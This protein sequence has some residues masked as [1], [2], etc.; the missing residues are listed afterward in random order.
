M[1]RTLKYLP[2]Y[3][4][5]A[6]S[7]LTLFFLSFS[8][9]LSTYTI[10]SVK[11][12]LNVYQSTT[13]TLSLLIVLGL[14][15]NYLRRE[16]PSSSI[17]LSAQSQ[18][19]DVKEKESVREITPAL[20]FQTLLESSHELI[21]ILNP[22]LKITYCSPYFTKLTGFT[23]K[24]LYSRRFF[25]LCS[26]DSRAALNQI[27]MQS[28]EEPEDSIAIEFTG[29]TK[30]NQEVGFKGTLLNKLSEPEI[31]GLVLNLQKKDVFSEER[32]RAIIDRVSD[33]F[34]SLN[35]EL[36][37][38]YA[39]K[40]IGEMTR[41]DPKTLIG[42]YIWDEFPE[43]VGSDTHRA[44]EKAIK[45]QVYVCN[46]DYFEPLNLWQEN[47][48]YPSR[49]GLSVFIR[50]IS[51][52]KIAELAL[53][54]SE[55]LFKALVENLEDIITIV[56]KEGNI[57]Y[58]SPAFER[59]TGFTAK[60]AIGTSGASFVHPNQVDNSKLLLSELFK[61]PGV[62]IKR[63]NQLL[64]KKGHY[65]WVEGSVINLLHDPNIKAI[66]SNYKDISDRMASESALRK[67]E[68]HY[69]NLFQNLIQAYAYCEIVYEGEKVVDFK[70]LAMNKA[71]EK[72][73]GGRDVIGKRLG[74]IYA[75]GNEHQ[76]IYFE[77]I[78]RLLKEGKPQ[79][80]EPY[81]AKTDKWYSVTFYSPVKDRVVIL[82]D[83]I[84]EKKKYNEQQSLFQSIVNSSQDAIF[85]RDQEGKITSWNLSA[86]KLFGY[87]TAE[88]LG[89][90]IKQLIPQ[91]LIHEWKDI[92]DR[93][94]AEIQINHFETHRLTKS[95]IEIP[96]SLTVSPILSPQGEF[97]GASIIARDI[98]E[99]QAAENKI[100][101]SETN[102]RTI[103]ENSTET[104]TLL[105]K[106]LTIKTFNSKAR[107]C[108]ILQFGNTVIQEN[109]YFLNYVHPERREQ[110]KQTLN[111]VLKGEQIQY[112]SDFY[113][114]KTKPY[115]FQA[116]F[117]PVTENNQV[118]GICVAVTDITKSKLAE[119]QI[120]E[121]EE[122][123]KAVFE[124]TTQGFLL[125]EPDGTIKLLNQNAIKYGKTAYGKEM[126][127]GKS[128]FDFIEAAR[129]DFLKAAFAKVMKGETISYAKSY[130]KGEGEFV[131]L[132]FSLS[133]VL[134]NGIPV[135]V[136]VTG[137]NISEKML[138]LQQKEFDQMNLKSLINNTS[139]LM[140]SIDRDF[141]LITS[142]AP[143]E[144]VIKLISGVSVTT[145]TSVLIK[146]FGEEALRRYKGYYERAFTGES[147]TVIEYNEVPES[148][149]SEISFHPIYNGKEIAGTACFSKDI[150]QSKKNAEEKEILIQELSQNNKDLKQFAYITSHNLR[151]P[152]ANLL[153]LTNLLDKHKVK[154]PTL[155]QIL[156]GIKKSALRFDETIKDLTAILTI[157]DNL[158]I[159]RENLS[160]SEIFEGAMT[161]CESLFTDSGASVF[162]DFKK[163]PE[164]SFNKS[165]LDSIFLNLITNA[166]KYRDYN[167]PLQIHVK[168][169]LN[170][171]QVVLEFSDNGIG[172]D[173]DANKDK[174]FKLYQRFHNTRE[175]KGLGLFLVK[176]QVEALGG[177]ISIESELDKGSR[178]IITFNAA[179]NL[180]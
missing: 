25:D 148:N 61:N 86:E 165:Y 176:S 17:H 164:I 145:G 26:K 169:R 150:T 31:N 143:F 124:N 118:V 173:L 97:R 75:E 51:E 58:V 122:N 111:R 152:I 131:W 177:N 57:Q 69:R 94:S 133:P 159:P 3:F 62:P 79:T 13:I 7:P 53:K 66:V 35:T 56:D 36:R 72:L 93:I 71:H 81:I 74:E 2:G 49:D 67:S 102:L 96:V 91:H 154:S 82:V 37:Y 28:F 139:D 9:I 88:A 106:E 47:H 83:D 46:T 101:N 103:F 29:L 20:S 166:L 171:G 119:N 95:G 172:I 73:L 144:E 14:V 153:G 39:N 104:F 180:A 87:S 84:T 100:K 22:E 178:F 60:D 11:P 68:E 16:K 89:M 19:I 157:K 32:F 99:R 174:I 134:N 156:A 12:Y 90:H 175:G 21:L 158:S 125:L 78:T 161:Q 138:S 149:W 52:K 80:I 110:L 162:A 98:S 6:E 38:T 43:A 5:P 135:G 151:G 168:T 163:A 45:E 141:R 107:E 76:E 77:A 54:K 116:S 114:T 155:N 112:S 34:F 120:L 136:C 167:R 8:F 109:T 41:R 130:D 142:N 127:T 170:Q 50:N 65:V 117:I 108:P 23:E 42:K 59:L 40:K 10:N 4:S 15:L 160:L 179:K 92:S 33:G 129:V 126:E 123:L 64:T 128:L 146:E 30:N 85:S 44:I 27:L 18:N 48:I 105:D 63:T 70:Y 115:W 137:N 132:D 147:F 113:S 121:S 140:W 24:E 55:S 1:K